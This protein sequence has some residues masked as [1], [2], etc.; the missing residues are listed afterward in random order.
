[1]NFYQLIEPYFILWTVSAGAFGACFGSF[2]NVVIWRV[3][4]GETIIVDTSHCPK[5][6]H[7]IRPWENIPIISWL[8]LRG[9]CS[10][11]RMSISPRYI[12]VES[13]TA[14]LWLTIWLHAWRLWS[15]HLVHPQLPYWPFALVCAYIV[16]ITVLVALTFI[17]IDH[18]IIPDGIIIFG[19]VVALTMAI[20]WPSSHEFTSPPMSLDNLRHK[21]VLFIVCRAL[22]SH[23][24][25]VLESARWLSVID[26]IG[27]VLL[28]GGIL[29]GMSEIGKLVY[30]KRTNRRKEAIEFCMNKNEIQYEEETDPWEDL[31]IREKDKLVIKGKLTLLKLRRK[32]KVKCPDPLPEQDEYII[33]EN[34]LHLGEVIVPLEDFK[35]VRMTVTEWVEPLE[36]MGLGDAT[37]MAMIGAFLGPGSVLMILC[38]ASILGASFGV[39]GMIGRAKKLGVAIPFGPYI[40]IATFFYILFDDLFFELYV[41][42]LSRMLVF[43]G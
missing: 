38:L 39:L 1:M 12:F 35:D 11:C 30:G 5:C 23:A 8:A 15:Q 18:R 32:S 24:K 2:L 27:G 20:A 42:L 17:D 43:Q 36:P 3:P 28:G 29:F 14:L 25:V 26:C 13:L 41:K 9:K 4:R 33:D 10:S 22:G 31:F 21:P 7:K 34:G 16:L 6:K 19:L 37:L 40:A